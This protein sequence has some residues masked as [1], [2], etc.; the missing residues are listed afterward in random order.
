MSSTSMLY[1]MGMALD[2]A[3]ENGFAVSLLVEGTWL[4]GQIA[5]SD[6]VGVVLETPDGQHCV[7]KTDRI[8]VVRI[9]AESPYKTPI[10]RGQDS[11]FGE[12]PTARPMP[13]PRSAYV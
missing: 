11:P 7:V 3:A 10:T 4:D 13:G 9:K 1:T 5:A 6:G 2:R 12:D 8:A